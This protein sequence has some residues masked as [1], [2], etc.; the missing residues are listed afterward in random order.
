MAYSFHPV[1]QYSTSCTHSGRLEDRNVPAHTKST[2]EFSSVTVFI[3]YIYKL[4]DANVQWLF[5]LIIHLL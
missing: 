4:A 5:S 2:S 3:R 1:I